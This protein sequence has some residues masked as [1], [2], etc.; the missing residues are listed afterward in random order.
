MKDLHL[1]LSHH[2]HISVPPE[3]HRVQRSGRHQ[4]GILPGVLG[5]E[6]HRNIL[7][8][9]P[10]GGHTSHMVIV[11]VG[12][13][14]G[15]NIQVVLLHQFFDLGH[16]IPGVDD[17]GR[18]GLFVGQNIAVCITIWNINVFNYHL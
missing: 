8:F 3:G 15:P 11:A 6:I 7:I 14:D 18:F 13:K 5:V 16:S 12:Q 2:H 4:L 9:F 10:Q 17:S 1:K